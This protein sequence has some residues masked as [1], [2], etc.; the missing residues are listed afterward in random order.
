MSALLDSSS[1][2]DGDEKIEMPTKVTLR[3]EDDRI[4]KLAEFCDSRL[5]RF[6]RGKG[7]CE[8]KPLCFDHL[9]SRA[10]E[11]FVRDELPG[12]SG[13]PSHDAHRVSVIELI[14]NIVVNLTLANV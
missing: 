12:V 8:I 9:I 1:A 4:A 14:Q 6:T 13:T 5:G 11:L 2:Q 10:H 3:N 7:R